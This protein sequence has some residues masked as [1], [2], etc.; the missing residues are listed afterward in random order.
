MLVVA[1]VRVVAHG[2][3]CLAQD[4]GC[5]GRGRAG[6]RGAGWWLCA[7]GWLGQVGDAAGRVVGGAD[8]SIRHSRWLRWRVVEDQFVIGVHPIAVGFR[9]GSTGRSYRRV[10]P[11]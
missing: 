8:R 5:P 1:V 3:S 7:V 10:R 9:S 11:L 4:L 2:V 6:R